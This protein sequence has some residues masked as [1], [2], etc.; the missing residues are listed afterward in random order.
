M[1]LSRLWGFL[2]VLVFVGGC[3]NAD[4]NVS[5]N[6]FSTQ[7]ISGF[8]TQY[9]FAQGGQVK[10]LMNEGSSSVVTLEQGEFVGEGCRQDTS[11]ILWSVK[12]KRDDNS[13]D[14]VFVFEPFLADASVVRVYLLFYPM[15]ILK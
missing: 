13:W 2:V 5:A 3:A 1:R 8:N 10:V 15:Q 11:E 14:K 9:D 7:V 12:C 6:S 4:T